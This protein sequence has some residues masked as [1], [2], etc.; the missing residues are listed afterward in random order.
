MISLSRAFCVSCVWLAAAGAFAQEPAVHHHEAEPAADRVWTW[1][2]DANVFV[3]LQLS[4]AA[5]CGFLGVGVAELVDGRR[6]AAARQRTSDSSRRCCRSSRSRLANWYTAAAHAFPPADRRSCFRPAR[7]ISGTP[8][9]NYQ[10][11]H[12]LI[13]GLGAT[14]RLER[15]A[16]RLHRRRGSGGLA[17]ARPDRV[18][19]SRVGAQQPAGAAQ[20]SLPRLDAHH[21]RRAARRCRNAAAS[22]SRRRCF[23]AKS[24]T[25]TA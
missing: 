20:P 18:H 3:G 9:V 2:G 12:D 17:D 23:A 21:H 15:D 7:A 10:H 24:R 1:S 6:R 22:R 25:K 5:V 8:L 4:A 11:P 13:M 14:Y 16:R 19:A